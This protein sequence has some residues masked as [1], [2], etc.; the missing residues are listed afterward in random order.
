MA[1]EREEEGEFAGQDVWFCTECDVMIPA[2]DA[3][4]CPDCG[5][6]MFQRIDEPGVWRCA[7]CNTAEAIEAAERAGAM[8]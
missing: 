4:G 5:E 3:K 8:I 6:D 1:Q 2:A 7:D